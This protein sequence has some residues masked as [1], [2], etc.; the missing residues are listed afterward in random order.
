MEYLN[1]LPFEVLLTEDKKI[2]PGASY[3]GIPFFV[4]KYPVSYVQSV[5]VL[6]T[7]IT[8][9]FDQ[10]QLLELSVKVSSRLWGS[11]V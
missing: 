1:Y 2:N 4:K 5:S 6:N 8:P 7:L 10:E 9:K 11:G 3:S